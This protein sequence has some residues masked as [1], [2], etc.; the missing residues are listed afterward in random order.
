M[1]GNYADS[2]NGIC[3]IFNKLKL[4]EKFK[5]HVDNTPFCGNH[6]DVTYNDTL[7]ECILDYSNDFECMDKIGKALYQNLFNKQKAWEYEKEY[8]F[9]INLHDI[10]NINPSIF[11]LDGINDCIEYVICGDN[12][13]ITNQLTIQKI[14]K[15]KK[16]Y[17]KQ[18]NKL[19]QFIICKTIMYNNV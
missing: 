19:E 7:P 1:W 14:L 9:T 5:D 15:G 16:F 12:M 2:N 6:G 3:L 17:S 18:L 8:R 13:S 10:N 11:Y 4:I